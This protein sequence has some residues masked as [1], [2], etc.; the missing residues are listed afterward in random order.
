MKLVQRH[1]TTHACS[2][3]PG[4]RCL[5]SVPVAR[6]RQLTMGVYVLAELKGGD[7]RPDT[8]FTMCSPAPELTPLALES[9]LYRTWAK[10]VTTESISL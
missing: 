9:R 10:S 5:R 1:S 3:R 2:L 6:W 4:P 7:R 8:V